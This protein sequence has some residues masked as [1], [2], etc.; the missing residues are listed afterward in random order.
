MTM[1]ARIEVECNG[2]KHHVSAWEPGDEEKCG[3]EHVTYGPKGYIIC[4]EDHD[5]ELELTIT[6]LTGDR[7]ECFR[8]IDESGMYLDPYNNTDNEVILSI[9]SVPDIKTYELTT[10]LLVSAARNSLSMKVVELFIEH[11]VRFEPI[12]IKVLH[13]AAYRGW[14][15]LVEFLVNHSF[16]KRI[17]AVTRLY[18]LSVTAE[19]AN[20]MDKDDVVEFLVSKGASRPDPKRQGRHLFKI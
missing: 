15:D 11:G 3:V 9:C 5:A 1:L 7:H 10:N 12:I 8:S 2:E 17:D 6:D 13:A 4:Y 14:L 20:L 16:F 19:K 18:E